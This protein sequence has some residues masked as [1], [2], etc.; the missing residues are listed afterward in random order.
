MENTVMD[1][2]WQKQ[3]S[4]PFFSTHERD[5]FSHGRSKGCDPGRERKTIPRIRTNLIA[6]ALDLGVCPTL[7]TRQSRGSQ[8]VFG[9][10]QICHGEK[11]LR[12]IDMR[13][14][15]YQFRNRLRN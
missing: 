11:A 12:Y 3:I 10:S 6:S 8:L 4:T 1:S 7:V 5:V 2:V 14:A 13:Y 15:K 9:I